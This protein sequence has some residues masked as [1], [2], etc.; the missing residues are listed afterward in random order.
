MYFYTTY[1]IKTNLM[2]Y[3]LLS[4]CQDQQYL[5]AMK[6][7]LEYP[8]L[9]HLFPEEEWTSVKV[10]S[11]MGTLQFRVM[12]N[13]FLAHLASPARCGQ[14]GMGFLTYNGSKISGEA[15]PTVILIRDGMR[16]G[17]LGLVIIFCHHIQVKLEASEVFSPLLSAWLTGAKHGGS[18]EVYQITLY[19]IRTF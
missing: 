13:G 6:E 7:I 14:A 18:V 2:M 10:L 16:E 8:S 15:T 4:R 1:L 3:T 12:S 11:L 19:P 9:L 5:H 17:K